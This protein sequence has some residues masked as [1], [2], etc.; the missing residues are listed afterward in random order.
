MPDAK[1]ARL[2]PTM[3]PADA[4]VS[5]LEQSALQ[6]SGC[7]ADDDVVCPTPRTEQRGSSYLPSPHSPDFCPLKRTSASKHVTK[8]AMDGTGRQLCY[9]VTNA[10]LWHPPKVPPKPHL[11]RRNVPSANA[12]WTL[13]G[14]A[15]TIDDDPRLI[16]LSRPHDRFGGAIPCLV[17]LPCRSRW[18]LRA[19]FCW[20][21][22][23]ALWIPRRRT[24][25]A[26]TWRLRSC[27][28]ARKVHPNASPR[29]VHRDRPRWP[30]RGAGAVSVGK[31]PIGPLGG[32]D[33]RG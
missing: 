2:S 29:G 8:K 16:P 9:T 24:A 22:T 28:A 13:A 18:R 20:T 27:L 11:P 26:M 19:L 25:A 17:P 15:L 1:R 32:G 21:A 33:G 23:A 4:S 31:G 6:G 10:P 7:E 30:R 12:C 14:C 3:S 5:A